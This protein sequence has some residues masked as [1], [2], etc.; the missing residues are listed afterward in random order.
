MEEVGVVA[1]TGPLIAFAKI[2]RL[3]LLSLLFGALISPIVEHELTAK[4]SKESR[5]LQSALGSLLLV[6]EQPEF[7]PEVKVVTSN[8]DVGEAAAIALAYSSHLG[9][10]IDDKLGR[11]AA[12]RLKI[13]VFGSAGIVLEASSMILSDRLVRLQ[14]PAQPIQI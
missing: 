8:L 11:R 5:R 2:D 10:V 14:L 9:L 13:P 6:A 7:A 1:D 3:D 4:R 12:S